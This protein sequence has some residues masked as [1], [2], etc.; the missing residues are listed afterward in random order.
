MTAL[1]FALLL[2]AVAMCS[3]LVGLVLLVIVPLALLVCVGVLAWAVY[4][5]LAR[6]FV[7]VF[8]LRG[9]R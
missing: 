6:L 1:G 5:A 4:Q 3:G 2:F 9:Y 7:S 8:V